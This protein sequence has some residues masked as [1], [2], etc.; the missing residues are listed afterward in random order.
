MAGDPTRF[1]LTAVGKAAQQYLVSPE[2]RAD[3]AKFTSSAGSFNAALL[4][5][6]GGYTTLASKN[7][8]ANK[9][10]AENTGKMLEKIGKM[11]IDIGILKTQ[12][13]PLLQVL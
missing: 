10:T 8:N 1:L 11:A 7:A 2:R 6:M 4:P 12:I 13:A 3:L 9:K 5:R